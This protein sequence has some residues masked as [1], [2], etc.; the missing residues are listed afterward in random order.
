[1]NFCQYLTPKQN[2]VSWFHDVKWDETRWWEEENP[3]I[4]WILQ[5]FNLYIEHS[6]HNFSWLPKLT[7]TLIIMTTSSLTVPKLLYLPSNFRLLI[8]FSSTPSWILTLIVILCH[9]LN[10]I[11]SQRKAKLY[12]FVF[13][14][15]YSF[16]YVNV[17]LNPS[18]HPFFCCCQIVNCHMH[19]KQ[20]I[21]FTQ[22]NMYSEIPNRFP[23]N[24]I[25][26]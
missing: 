22:S 24:T 21:I 23:S 7:I 5:E 12:C 8:C 11:S 18:L 26:L 2:C 19:L 17:F 16:W 14:N 4:N 1:M 10:S 25:S 20:F 9:F 15:Y 6:D 13:L 3:T